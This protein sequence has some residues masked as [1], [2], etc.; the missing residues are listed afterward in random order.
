MAEKA[1]IEGTREE[2]EL[3]GSTI[4]DMSKQLSP[5]FTIRIKNK[6]K[7]REELTGEIGLLEFIG[8]LVDTGEAGG[9]KVRLS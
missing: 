6:T 7:V 3:D 5:L 9:Q 2:H 8:V 1:V 4:T